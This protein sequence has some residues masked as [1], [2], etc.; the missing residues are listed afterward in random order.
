MRPHLK[1]SS[2]D[3]PELDLALNTGLRQNELFQLRWTDISLRVGL[4]T[5]TKSKSGKPRHVNLNSI[6]VVAFEQLA[7]P[8]DDMSSPVR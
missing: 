4:L 1:I 2:E 7:T 6:A 3:L 8:R 5:V